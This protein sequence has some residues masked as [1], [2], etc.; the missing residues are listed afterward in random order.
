MGVRPLFYGQDQGWT[1]VSNDLETVLRCTNAEFDPVGLA[2]HAVM[3]HFVEGRTAFRRVRQTAPGAWLRF[4]ARTDFGKHWDASALLEVERQRMSF[5]DFAERFTEILH[6]RMGWYRSPAVAMTLTGGLDSRMILAALLKRGVRPQTYT[7][8]SPE[9]ADATVAGKVARVLGLQH[10]VRA[11]STQSAEEYGRVARRVVRE[12]DSLA[13]LHRAHRLAALEEQIEA[14]GRPD[15]LLVGVLGGES[16]RGVHLGDLLV[17][18]YVRRRW[19]RGER[20]QDLLSE[21]LERYFIRSSEIDIAELS[22]LLESQRLFGQDAKTNEFYAVFDIICSVHHTR[23]LA[24]YSRLVPHVYPVFM[25]EDYLQLLFSSPYSMLYRENM[26]TNQLRRLDSPELGA[27]VVTRLSP[28]LGRIQLSKGYSP[29]E[30]TMGRAVYVVARTM[31][32]Q[33]RRPRPANY[34][35][36]D[37]FHRLMESS[38]A[39]ES[40]RQLDVAFDI[41]KARRQLAVQRPGTDELSWRPYSDLAFADMVARE[42]SVDCRG[43][44]SGESPTFSVNHSRRTYD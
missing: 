9:S 7:Y 5:G 44:S 22:A 26:S 40:M 27:Q 39:R 8:G 29:R 21:L 24:L 35:Y 36:G 11:W 13:H 2:S 42:Y 41:G 20:P 17:T 33:L 38:L 10:S 23:D 19:Q 3:H 34:P 4:G 32:K 16:N 43:R 25:E 30:Y 1:V 37:W 12:G 18:E 14:S 6:H 31:R 28:V 15:V